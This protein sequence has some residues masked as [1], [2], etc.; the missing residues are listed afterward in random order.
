MVVLKTSSRN[1]RVDDESSDSEKSVGEESRIP[2]V[3]TPGTQM[4]KKL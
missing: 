3:I 2:S 4:A 1:S